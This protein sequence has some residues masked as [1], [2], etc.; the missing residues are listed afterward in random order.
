MIFKKKRFPTVM[1][2]YCSESLGMAIL[3]PCDFGGGISSEIEGVA[4]LLSYDN[5]SNLGQAF[6]DSLGKTTAESTDVSKMGGLKDWPAFIVS[7][8]KAGKEFER[9]YTRYHVRGVNESNHFYKITSPQLPNGIELSLSV[10]AH[11]IPL[12]IGIEIF[13]IHEY[14][15]ECLKNT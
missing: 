4:V 1:N 6:I 2:I 7:G 8:L 9:K 3:A 5:P 15:L 12:Q 13:K 11:E 14:Y 10:K